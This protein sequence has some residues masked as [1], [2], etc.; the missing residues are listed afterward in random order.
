MNLNNDINYKEISVDETK[1]LLKRNPNAKL[2]DVR[3]TE[4][5]MKYNV[6]QAFNLTNETF[7]KFE[8][9][10]KKESPVVVMCYHGINS[11]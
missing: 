5:F 10:T 7:D 11:K 4:T 1:N 9:L 3:D 2:V 6:E 8:K